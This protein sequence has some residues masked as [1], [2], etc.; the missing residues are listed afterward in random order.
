[1]R[2]FKTRKRGIRKP[3]ET[4]ARLRFRL[5]LERLAFLYLP[6]RQ[7]VSTKEIKSHRSLLEPTIQAQSQTEDHSAGNPQQNGGH[8]W[9]VGAI[10]VGKCFSISSLH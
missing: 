5:V 7:Q 1:V 9:E 3:S 2:N 6:V 10:A 8:D 4:S